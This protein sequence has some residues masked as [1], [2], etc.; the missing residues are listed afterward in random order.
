[1]K[2]NAQKEV[3][4]KPVFFHF[5]M[6][7]FLFPSFFFFIYIHTASQ[8]LKRIPAFAYTQQKKEELQESVGPP[9]YAT[10]CIDAV[11]AT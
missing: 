1:M 3:A 10:A 8:V 11:V 2:Y 9:I 5:T 7:F 4:A 6:K